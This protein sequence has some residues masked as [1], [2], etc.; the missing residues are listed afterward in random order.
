MNAHTP[1]LKANLEGPLGL[2]PQAVDYLIALWETIQSLDD[3]VDGDESTPEEKSAAIWNAVAGFQL[4]P[5]F[6]Q[7]PCVGWTQA[8]QWLK[9]CCADSVERTGE[10]NLHLAYAWRAG[11]YDVVLQCVLIA[12]GAIEAARLAPLVMALYGEPYED[13][14][15]EFERA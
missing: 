2:P 10:G 13:Y 1:S 14:A 5:W 12:H 6:Q 15:K 3:W 8:V 7:N 4:H 11:F 9:Y